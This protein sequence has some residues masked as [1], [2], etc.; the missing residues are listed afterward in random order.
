MRGGKEELDGVEGSDGQTHK[1]GFPCCR[2]CVRFLLGW[3]LLSFD[4]LLAVGTGNSR[5]K[6]W[7]KVKGLTGLCK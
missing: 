4:P 5:T 1:R 3:E 2:L 6:H 7:G